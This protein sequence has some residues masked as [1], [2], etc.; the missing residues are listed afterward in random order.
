MDSLG[1]NVRRERNKQ[2]DMNQEN[3][4]VFLSSESDSQLASLQRHADHQEKKSTFWL[5]V[6]ISR[7]IF[8]FVVLKIIECRLQQDCD[9]TEV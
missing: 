7:E 4:V 1:A 5:R 9:E 3:L 6:D 2:S 8:T